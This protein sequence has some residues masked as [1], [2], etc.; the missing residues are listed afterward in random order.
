MYLRL[1]FVRGFVVKM[2]ILDEIQ[3]T[4]QIQQISKN[5]KTLKVLKYKNSCF[6]QKFVWFLIFNCVT[7]KLKLSHKSSLRKQFH[8]RS[9][10]EVFFSIFFLSKTE[11]VNNYG[12]NFFLVPFALTHV[13]HLLFSRSKRETIKAPLKSMK[14]TIL[15]YP[16]P[17]FALFF[18]SRFI[19]S[20][21]LWPNQRDCW[22]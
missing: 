18:P 13:F 6:C 8:C 21:L 14:I 19:A 17:R 1:R 5:Q 7:N 2:N 9:K 22:A 11:S 20:F 10:K 4:Q 3:Q 12:Y 15:W 16:F